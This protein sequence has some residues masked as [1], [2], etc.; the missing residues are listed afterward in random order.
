MISI[1]SIQIKNQLLEIKYNP[2][3]SPAPSPKGTSYDTTTTY[4]W[5]CSFPVGSQ[6][7]S[8]KAN[9]YYNLPELSTSLFTQEEIQNCI[10]NGVPD[11]SENSLF[12]F[13]DYNNKNCKINL[14]DWCGLCCE[15]RII[16]ENNK[17]VNLLSGNK[18]ENMNIGYSYFI[19]F[20]NGNDVN[21]F[22]NSNKDDIYFGYCAI[23]P[24]NE[25]C[26]TTTKLDNNLEFGDILYFKSNYVKSP[27]IYMMVFDCCGSCINSLT[28]KNTD[29]A[30]P[31]VDNGG[32]DS[33]IKIPPK[34]NTCNGN[35]SSEQC[36]EECYC[37]AYDN[38]W[39]LNNNTYK[40]INDL[41]NS[42][43]GLSLDP[44]IHCKSYPKNMRLGC[45]NWNQLQNKYFSEL[46]GYGLGKQNNND[47]PPTIYPW[48]YNVLKP[49]S[50]DFSEVFYNYYFQIFKQ[51]YENTYPN[52]KA[53]KNK[54]NYYTGYITSDLHFYNPANSL[55]ALPTPIPS[56][57]PLSP[58]CNV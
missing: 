3:G 4:F 54:N 43:N 19:N 33:C 41:W 56:P 1:K 20:F 8:R 42:N 10:K 45:N 9:N 12:W 25:A 15:G 36:Q 11:K 31:V 51:Y 46:K 48:V 44:G 58:A 47:P 34:N 55:K 32:L 16:D 23:R 30:I 26:D 7:T 17:G 53:Q 37:W 52:L 27:P 22:N 18:A 2:K 21:L 49:G 28:T 39:S 29:I 6:A 13:N 38:K 40:S 50:K 5:D 57:Y 24:S 14:G 35:C